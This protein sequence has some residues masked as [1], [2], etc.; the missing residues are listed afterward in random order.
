MK[1]MKFYEYLYSINSNKEDELIEFF[2]DNEFKDYYLDNDF[3]TNLQVL[4]LYTSYENPND[5]I[6]DELNNKFNFELLSKSVVIEKDW[7]KAWLDTLE[8]FE[9]VK[10]IWINPFPEK[11]LKNKEKVIKIIPGTAFG[12]GLHSTTKLAGRILNDMNCENKTVID[13]GCGTGILSILA[14]L[15]GAKD[16]YAYDYDGLAIE[17]AIET[18]EINNLDIKVK[19]SNFLENVNED[20]KSDIF[21]SNMVAEILIELLKDEKFDGIIKEGSYVIFSG[22]MDKK[23]DLIM[24]KT[25]EHNLELIEKTEEGS[26]IGLKLQKKK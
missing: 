25:K 20:I 4:K 24:E 21:V 23:I 18:I 9:F 1:K 13:M 15:K 26:W 14:K 11:E 8:V 16:V 10:D 12:T 5:N 2:Y 6:I 22:I 7:L 3:K 17:K 19:Q